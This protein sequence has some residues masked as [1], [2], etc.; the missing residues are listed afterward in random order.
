MFAQY[1]HH[2]DP[3][4]GP[5]PPSNTVEAINASRNHISVQWGPRQYCNVPD[6]ESDNEE[7]NEAIMAAYET[8]LM[9]RYQ[10]ITSY[11]DF[12][13]STIAR[14]ARPGTFAGMAIRDLSQ[15]AHMP[16]IIR[17][18][19]RLSVDATTEMTQDTHAGTTTAPESSASAED[20]LDPDLA[21]VVHTLQTRSA[22][23]STAAVSHRAGTDSSSA[24]PD[25]PLE[26]PIFPANWVTHTRAS[27]MSSRQPPITPGRRPSRTGSI[28]Y[29]ISPISNQYTE[30]GEG[31]DS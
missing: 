15:P 24:D 14:P 26:T 17:A 13:A 27:F 4:D 29:T 30:G 11:N 21:A 6:D 12:I 20:D 31:D 22:P 19:A 16:P 10:V 25:V 3:A 5:F 9:P 2:Y 1:Y 23:A 28:N 18:G 7:N 8:P